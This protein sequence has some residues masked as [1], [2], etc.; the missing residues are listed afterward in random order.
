MNE[1]SKRKLNKILKK[2]RLWLYNEPKGER[3]D[4]REANLRYVNLAGADLREADLRGADFFMANFEDADLRGA[5]FEGADLRG[6][7]LRYAHFEGADLQRTKLVDANLEYSVFHGTNLRGADLRGAC[8]TGVDFDFVYLDNI[9]LSH[10]YMGDAENVHYPIACPEKGSFTAFKKAGDY[11][12]ELFIPS[13]A[14]RSSATSRK[15]RCDKAKVISITTLA[16][17]KT[18]VTEVR[19]DYDPSFIYKIGEYVTVENFNE[20]RWDECSTGIHFFITREE[21]VRY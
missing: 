6:A 14:K 18:D 5:D 8:V 16:G 19:S 3:A 13:D 9:D 17:D 4:L 10:V 7:N 2:H 21:A 12:V 20:D 1:K 11:I 15:C